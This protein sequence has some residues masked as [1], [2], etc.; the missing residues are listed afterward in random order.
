MQAFDVIRA[1]DYLGARSDLAKYRVVLVGEGL[2]GVWALTAAALDPRPAGVIAVGTVPSY[3][4]IVG[5]KYYAS[6]DYFWVPGAL[7][8]FDLPDLI[9]LAAPRPAV[10]VDPADAMLAPLRPDACQAICASPLEIYRGLGVADR[11]RLVHTTQGTAAQIAEA[12][13]GALDGM[14]SGR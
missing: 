10:L 11:M 8:D 13:A 1:I 2:G 4:L 14:G 6:R 7:K 3:K 9:G 5:A 12:V